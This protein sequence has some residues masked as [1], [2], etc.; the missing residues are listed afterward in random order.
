MLVE[1]VMTSDVVKIDDKKTVF[2]ACKEF[3]KHKVG[4][5]VVMDNDITVGIVTERDVIE[6][7]VLLSRDPKKTKIIDIMSPNIKTIHALAPLEKAVKMMK[8]NNIKKLP[9][10]LNNEI[11]G[12]LTETDLSRTVEAFS[13]TL[14]EFVKFY[15]TSRE[16]IDRIMDEWEQILINLQNYRKPS[17]DEELETLI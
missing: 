5:L 11:V 8:E 4:S 7:A 6:K 14:E 2:E 3:S 13:E 16:N 12:I 1:E 17:E 9:V 10:I 15:Q